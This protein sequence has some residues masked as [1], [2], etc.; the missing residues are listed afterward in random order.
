[1]ILLSISGE[2]ALI[3]GALIVGCY[4][5]GRFAYP[6]LMMSTRV[7]QYELIT[8][9][10]THVGKTYVIK[11]VSEDETSVFVEHCVPQGTAFYSTVKDAH[12]RF[13]DG[14]GRG[15]LVDCFISKGPGFWVPH[16]L[17]FRDL[18]P[19]TLFD[20]VSDS[21]STPSIKMERKEKHQ[22]VFLTSVLLR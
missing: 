16:Q 4:L 17:F 2:N 6:M 20:V 13:A 14:N 21:K 18:K 8:F 19:G 15:H 5:F 1:M 10:D 11:K 9:N 22:G 7:E 12:Y 3:L